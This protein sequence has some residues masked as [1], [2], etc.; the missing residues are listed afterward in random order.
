MSSRNAAI[1]L[2][3]FFIYSLIYG[4]FVLISAFSP[5]VMEWTPIAGVNLAIW[6]GF[7][8]IIIALALSLVY[9]W[10]CRNSASDRPEDQA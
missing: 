5:A 10:L 4:G 3:L 2:T 9:G 1:G 8:L 7:G 6:Y